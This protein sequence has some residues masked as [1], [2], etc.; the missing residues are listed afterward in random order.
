[1]N[2]TAKIPPAEMA[3][4]LCDDLT[5]KFRQLANLPDAR[6]DEILAGLI[7]GLR[8]DVIPHPFEGI[9]PVRRS[10]DPDYCAGFDVGSTW[11]KIAN[12]WPDAKGQ[13]CPP[14]S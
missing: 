5:K 6:A 14:T 11:R 8:D 9:P 2:W 10:M 12:E 1:M 7:A 3:V 13:G 4:V